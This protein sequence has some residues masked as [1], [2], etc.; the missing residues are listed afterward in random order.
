[1]YANLIVTLGD[2]TQLAASKVSFDPLTSKLVLTLDE[3]IDDERVA[4][5]RELPLKGLGARQ[6]SIVANY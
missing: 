6:I 4:G 1:M 5:Y 3:G 2:G